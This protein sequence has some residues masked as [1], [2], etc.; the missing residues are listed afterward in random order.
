[1]S[2]RRNLTH[3][4]LIYLIIVFFSLAFAI[5]IS[6]KT[7]QQFSYIAQSFLHG[8]TYFLEKPITWYDTTFFKGKYY[9]PLAP[10][11]S[12]LLV[13][14]MYIATLL[15]GFFYQG[16]L[17][18]FI[19]LGVFFLC[20][21]IA[22]RFHYS[23]K[24]SLFLAFAF[25]FS[26]IY[27]LVALMPWSWYFVQAIVVFCLLLAIYEFLNKRRYLIIGTL[28]AMIFASRFTAGFGL[29]FFIAEV[30]F[31][32]KN[33]PFQQKFKY[34]FFL[35]AP[36]LISGLLL[37]GYNY[38]RFGDVFDNGYV[39][40]N[41]VTMTKAQRFELLNYGLFNI[42]NV[43]TNFYYYFI[44]S[45]D[46]ILIPFT[47][48]HGNTY[49]LQPP[50][51][52]VAYP[53]TSFFIASPIF[54]YMLRTKI[55]EKLVKLSLIPIITILCILLTYFWPG[56]RQVGPRYLLDL[57]PFAYI[58]LL[59][60]FKGFHLNAVAKTVIISSAI[61]DLYLFSTIFS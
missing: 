34:L 31:Y 46:P 51:V 48:L 2:L 58:V 27:L 6:I 14:F 43:P 10:F 4:L 61:L 49:I 28:F 17:Q 33:V 11:P 45:L 24:D 50:Y 29:I 21:R 54:I 15:E 55:R 13:P 36:V 60:S 40:T 5:N 47:S 39:A 22:R 56:W 38:I 19:T 20:L 41:N 26:S 53:G 12:V 7:E 9:W 52:R 23:K 44:K 30:I 25:C 32:K 1:M 37:L 59:Y 8:K 35:I 18:F 16:Y 3:Y 57:L 42:K